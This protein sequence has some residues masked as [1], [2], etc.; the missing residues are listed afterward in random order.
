M[1]SQ[2]LLGLLARGRSH[3][4]E[5]KG[6]LERAFGGRWEINF[7]QLYTT[8]GRLERDGLVEVVAE[9]SEGRGKR[10]YALT[11]AG[12][13][14]LNAWLD[15]P[16]ERADWLKDEFFVKLVVRH[17]AGY[18][19]AAALVAAQRQTDLQRLRELRT[20]AHETED[21][22]FTSLLLE[23]A[24]LHLQADLRWLDLCDQRLDEL[25]AARET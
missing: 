13:A 16:V 18:G 11:K 22:P 9:D 8:L 4:Y 25:D 6:A 24:M 21:S 23:S 3:G 12:R 10:T 19:D 1:L 2:A 20:L 7:G 14:E 17:L 5:L 15:R